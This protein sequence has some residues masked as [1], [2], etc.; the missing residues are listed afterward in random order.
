MKLIMPAVIPASYQNL[1]EKLAYFDQVRAHRVQIDMVDGVFAE[2]ASWPYTALADLHDR[3]ATGTLLPHVDRVKYEADL[4]CKD[5]EAIVTQLVNMGVVRLTLHAEC[6]DNIS[7]LIARIRHLVGAEANFVAA[8]ISI[9]LSINVE[10]DISML[11][12]HSEEVEYVQFM[13]ITNIGKQGQPFDPRVIEKVRAFRQA[14]PNA[15]I[16]V[17]GGVTFDIAKELVDA[18]ASRL[19]AGSL[20]QNATDLPATMARL[21]ALRPTYGAE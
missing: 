1:L 9:G 19:V 21:E 12:D 18:G 20:F 3:A 5:P 2:P 13:G 16:Q 17:D 15:Y 4:L 14:R 10:T 11:L 7:G 8:L 6:T